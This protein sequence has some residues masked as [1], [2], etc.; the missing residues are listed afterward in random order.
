MVTLDFLYDEVKGNRNRTN[1]KIGFSWSADGIHWPEQN[2][3]IVD[4]RAGLPPGVEPWWE[5]VRTPH[6]LIDEGHGIYSCYFTATSRNDRGF[7][8]VGLVRLRLRELR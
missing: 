3:Q 7:R 1:S 2:G 6:A 8:G 5:T 4:L